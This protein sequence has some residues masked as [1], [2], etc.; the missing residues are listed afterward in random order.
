MYTVQYIPFVLIYTTVTLS[1]C[2]SLAQFSDCIHYR[3][4]QRNRKM[5][6]SSSQYSAQIIF[7]N[8]SLKLLCFK[9]KRKGVR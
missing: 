8:N 3:Q 2:S 1:T 5:T 7:H 4:N 6:L 9:N